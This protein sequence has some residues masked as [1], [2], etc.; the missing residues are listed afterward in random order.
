MKHIEIT[1]FSA[2]YKLKKE[3]LVALDQ[4]SLCVEAG[5]F[6]TLMGPSGCGKTTLLKCILG[7]VD[8]TEGTLLIRG[9]EPTND[10]IKK[11]NIA[12]VAQDFS[13]YQHLNVYENI[14]F[15]LRMAEM[16][17][18]EVDARVRAMAEKC[19]LHPALLNRKPK[20]LSR[21]QQQRVALARAFIKEPEIILMDEPFA[22]LDAPLRAEF[23]AWIRQY[24]TQTH[25]T[26]LFVTHDEEEA[27]TLGGR[28][29][30]MEDG[31]IISSE[32]TGTYGKA[33]DRKETK[34]S[35]VNN[36]EKPKPQSRKRLLYR[37]PLYL[38]GLVA[39]VFI[40]TTLW[41]RFTAPA[42]NEKLSVCIV[43]QNFRDADAQHTLSEN[44]KFFTDQTLKELTVESLYHDNGSLLAEALT[45]R[46]VG[47]TDFII[48]EDDYL[49][50]E[51]GSR[52]FSEI[53]AEIVQQY[54]PGAVTY[55][56]N[57]HIYGI[58]V[59]SPE[60]EDTVFS[61]YYEGT[62]SCWLFF[63]IVSENAAGMNGKGAESDTAALDLAAYLWRADS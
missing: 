13:L 5:E 15:P 38:L 53:P 25:A 37:W 50:E 14:A 24:Y 60:M 59:H 10:V 1:D 26:F 32:D 63:T 42:M 56:E 16:A 19:G 27:R 31:E 29:V 61:E 55:E 46:C 20:Q 30:Y 11:A 49:F 43:G 33:T 7:Q 3:Y 23:Q 22:H 2:Y 45:V 9:E 4:V 51:I 54:F 52:Y 39:L 62:N 18:E 35:P 34:E 12:Y 44:P 48:L 21:G 17:P 47:E 41:N 28:L 8:L 57:G 58:C 6:V 36:I 40:I